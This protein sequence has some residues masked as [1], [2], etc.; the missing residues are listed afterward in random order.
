MQLLREA[1]R[2]AGVL[3]VKRLPRGGGSR[4]NVSIGLLAAAPRA[5]SAARASP[6]KQASSASCELAA[7]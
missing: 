1:A 5:M 2:A 7:R 3:G 4:S 6:A